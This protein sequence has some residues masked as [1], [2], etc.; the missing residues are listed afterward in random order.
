VLLPALLNAVL[1]YVEFAATF[2]FIPILARQAGATDILLSTLLSSSILVMLLGNLSAASLVH[3]IGV[4][5]LLTANV[6]L[7]AL[8]VGGAAFASSLPL[9]F[10]CQYCISFSFGIGYPILMGL[11]IQPV[12]EAER[13]TAMGLHQSVYSL[14]MFTGPWL[15]GILAVRLGIQPMFFVTG[16]AAL[17]LG[18]VGTRVLFHRTEKNILTPEREAAQDA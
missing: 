11:S 15:S 2:S 9:I 17:V 10:A 8:G 13:T 14:G 1:Q 18:L 3:R 6:A 7:V 12:G 16:I 4:R 5:R